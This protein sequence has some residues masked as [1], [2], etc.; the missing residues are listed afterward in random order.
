MEV[1]EDLFNERDKI[2]IKQIPLSNRYVGNDSWYW[3]VEE[4]GEFIVRS[5]YRQIRGEQIYADKIFWKCLWG[6]KLPGKIL[7][8]TS[9]CECFAN[10]SSFGD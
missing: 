8:V 10:N 7:P 3:I 9:L 6:L 2:L 5:C 4:K 1:L